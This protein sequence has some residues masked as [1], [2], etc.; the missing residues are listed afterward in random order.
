MHKNVIAVSLLALLLGSPAFADAYQK[1][2]EQIQKDTGLAPVQIPDTEGAYLGKKH[3]GYEVIYTAKAGNVWGR[4]AAR[5]TMGE[6]G[7]EVGGLLGYMTGQREAL[8]SQVVGSPLDR[9]LSKIIGQPLAVTVIL[10]HGKPAAPRLDV[11]SKYSVLANEVDMPEQAKIGFKAGA[12]Y[13]NDGAFAAR[14]AGN[15]QLMNR[16]K[17]LRCQYIRV[18]G[19]A[20]T[21]LWSGSETDYSGMINDHGGYSKMLNA[22][23]DDLADIADAI[24]G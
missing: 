24:T 3:R 16:M 21:F 22:I 13:S 11:V 19:D 6:V 20:V 10:K 17:S 4:Y 18:D 8:G 14:L 9:A 15:K 23:M 12:I 2:L 1:A 7:H 5:L